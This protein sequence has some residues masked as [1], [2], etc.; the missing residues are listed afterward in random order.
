MTKKKSKVDEKSCVS[1]GCCIKVCPKDAIEVKNG[2]Y[3]LI[4]HDLCIGCGKCVVECPASIIEG[5]YSKKSNKVRFKKWYDYLW[6]FSIVYF[7]LGFFN[8]IFAWLGMICFILP[9]LFAIFG[10][11]KAFCNRYCDRG[12]LLGLLGDV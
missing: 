9:L 1:C 4:N 10:G 8:I 2:M 3:A 7:T 6:I 5:E 11:N 12:Q